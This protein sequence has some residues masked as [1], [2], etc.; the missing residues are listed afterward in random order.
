M[1][2][3]LGDKLLGVQDLICEYASG[4]WGLD[5]FDGKFGDFTFNFWSINKDGSGTI[6]VPGQT[7]T[8]I[9]NLSLYAQGS[10]ED[11]SI[12]ITYNFIV[13][14]ESGSYQKTATLTYPACEVTFPTDI[15]GMNVGTSKVVA[16]ADI[17]DFTHWCTKSTPAMDAG[18]Q[19]FEKGS[20]TTVL[21]NM[22][23]YAVKIVDPLYTYS[24][25]YVNGGDRSTTVY[26]S[27]FTSISVKTGP[28][29]FPG[30]EYPLYRWT[31]T[32]GGKTNNY[33]PGNNI[34]ITAANPD[35]ILT[36][37]WTAPDAK[38][39]Y[40]Y[41]VADGERTY[42]QNFSPWTSISLIRP[43]DCIRPGYELL[44]WTLVDGANYITYSVEETVVLSGNQNLYA[45]WVKEAD[46]AV[47]VAL[48][49][50]QVVS[51]G[52]EHVIPVGYNVF[53]LAEG[54]ALVID[55]CYR[56]DSAGVATEG[57][58]EASDPGVYYYAAECHLEVD[59]D[60]IPEHTYAV[61]ATIGFIA[62]T[63]DDS[64][65]IVSLGNN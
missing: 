43:V 47:I 11:R 4:L 7:L 57:E 62:I 46:W 12:S 63:N 58:L 50:S 1:S 48:M 60:L 64:F 30:S 6:Y 29:I 14:D 8:R 41:A 56:C 44:G 31:C 37:V 55:R 17:A 21:V 65:S 53:G 45:L 35:V 42:V 27:T 54:Y 34:T 19:L 32:V 52:M 20:T 26:Q 2:Y 49:N 9:S 3:Y 22:T 61:W 10:V 59:K 25:T 15:S 5:K 38:I 36:P 23:L 33:I 39:T 24:L 51:D 28:N 18:T 13:S 40:H 16:M